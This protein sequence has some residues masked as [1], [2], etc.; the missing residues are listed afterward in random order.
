MNMFMSGGP[1]FM[2]AL[3]ILL[4]AVFFAAWKAPRWVKDIGTIALVFGFLC[5]IMGIQQTIG[6]FREVSMS[7]DN[8]SGIFDLISPGVLFGALKASFNTVIYGIIIYLIALI[9]HIIQKPRV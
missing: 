1:I 8:V 4:V 3:T 7:L 2:T 6:T 5:Q 9:V